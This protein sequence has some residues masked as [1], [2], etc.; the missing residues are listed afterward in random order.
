MYNFVKNFPLTKLNEI[1][2]LKRIKKGDDKAF[3]TIFREYYSALCF[4][5]KKFTLQADIAEEIVQN[6]FF[7]L[8]EMRVELK[9]HTSLKSYLFKSV[10]NNSIK[11]LNSKKFEEDYRKFN[12]EIILNKR[13][14]LPDFDLSEKINKSIEELPPQCRKIFILNRYENLKHKEIAKKLGIAEKTVEVQIRRANM[15]LR[16]KL[17]EYL[18]FFIFLSLFL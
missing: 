15:A 14:Y 7:K 12:E 2:L 4:Y 3:E 18:P 11:Y 9:I 17:Q 1:L 5:A 13:D 8:W 10:H 6:I 16:K